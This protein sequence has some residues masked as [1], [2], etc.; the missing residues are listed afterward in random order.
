M[1]GTQEKNVLLI[2]KGPDIM[3][4]CYL[5]HATLEMV[6]CYSLSD[7]AEAKGYSI[8]LM[9][10]EDGPISFDDLKKHIQSLGGT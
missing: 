7:L 6:E 8:S 10:L 5:G 3:Y 2:N 4:V 1:I 9:E